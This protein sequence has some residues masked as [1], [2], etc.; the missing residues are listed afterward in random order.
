MLRNYSNTR[1]F[2]FLFGALLAMGPMTYLAKDMETGE[3]NITLER[4]YKQ[5]SS[6]PAKHDGIITRSRISYLPNKIQ[7]EESATLF[8][9]F[10]YARVIS[11]RQSAAGNTSRSSTASEYVTPTIIILKKN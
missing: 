4:L 3:Y 11:P 7:Q 5:A 9:S 10:V 2:H 8:F 1:L 6:Q